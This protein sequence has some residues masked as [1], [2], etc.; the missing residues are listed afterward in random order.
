MGG[1]KG[2]VCIQVD[3]RGEVEG[4]VGMGG[5]AGKVERRGQEDDLKRK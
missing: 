4:V 5:K 1:W 2:S 3:W